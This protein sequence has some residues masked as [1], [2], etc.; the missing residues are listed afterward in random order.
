M[1]S[2]PKIA[3]N[4]RN[5][6]K[7]TGPRTRTGKGSA[8]RNALRHGFNAVA[9]ACPTVEE[10]VERL[11]AMIC[12]GQTDAPIG[13]QALIIAEAEILLMRIR[14]ARAS[15]IDRAPRSPQ[16]QGIDRAQDELGLLGHLESLRAALPTL[17]SS[18]RYE[19]RAMS[20]RRKAIRTLSALRACARYN[21]SS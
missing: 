21:G 6:T 18:E 8:S 10:K 7:S 11:A 4:R 13:E 14:A 9:L 20:R 19:R 12:P 2:I 17:L 1:T 5:A 3:A 15:Q 16:E